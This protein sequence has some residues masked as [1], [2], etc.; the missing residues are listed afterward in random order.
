MKFETRCRISWRSELFRFTGG[1]RF[2]STMV[3]GLG[4]SIATLFPNAIDSRTIPSRSA[5]QS[6]I[7]VLPNTSPELAR[8]NR[9]GRRAISSG[10]PGSKLLAFEKCPVRPGFRRIAFG[11]RWA[12]IKT[13]VPPEKQK[14]CCGEDTRPSEGGPFYRAEFRLRAT[15]KRDG[16][17]QAEGTCRRPG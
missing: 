9:K 6:F 10:L 5:L 12:R 16:P 17:F 4:G 2:G 3:R 8:N 7:L 14:N 15:E 1:S 11:E 13:A